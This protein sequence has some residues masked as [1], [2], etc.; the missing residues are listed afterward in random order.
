MF[1]QQKKAEKLE[2]ANQDREILSA[3]IIDEREFLLAKREKLLV[4]FEGLLSPQTQ[5]M[6]KKF[7]LVVRYL[8]YLLSE[9]DKRL[10]EI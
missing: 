2:T 9:I 1:N 10:Q 4:L 3:A 6:E 8:Q 5:S 7:E